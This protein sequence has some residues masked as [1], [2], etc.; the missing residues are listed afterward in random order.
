MVS[1]K[2]LPAVQ[3][4]NAK[5]HGNK[6][7]KQSGKTN[8]PLI[9][10]KNKSAANLRNRSHR[11]ER[12]QKDNASEGRI[13]PDKLTPA[14]HFDSSLNVSISEPHITGPRLSQFAP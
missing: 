6:K 11:L 2:H 4:R 13:E 8:L 1:Q 7:K 3:P 14:Q 5:L 10:Q 9:L 12:S